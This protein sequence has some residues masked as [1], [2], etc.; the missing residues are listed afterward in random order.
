MTYLL[1]TNVISEMRRPERATPSVVS[2]VRAQP[3]G[4]L[5]CSAVTILELEIGALQTLRRDKVQGTMLRT[6][7]DGQV[8]PRF[9]GRI[10]PI[11]KAVAL[12][13]AALHVPDPRPDRDAYI[14]AT[15]LIHGLTMVTRNVRDFQPTGVKLLNPWEA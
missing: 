13:S 11:D 8:L 15:A 2:W 1:D 12:K 6:W 4:S 3:E 9:D 7:I 14:A 10:V 5:L